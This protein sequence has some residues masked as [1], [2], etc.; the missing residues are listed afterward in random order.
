MILSAGMRTDIPAFYS[1]W[2]IN[3]VREGYVYVRNPYFRNKVTKY[4]ISPNV[5]DLLCFGTKNPHPM[6]DY[7]DELKQNYK[8]LWYITITPYGKD[9]EPNVQDKRQ[10]IE[11]VKVLSNKLGY[12]SIMI[13]YDPIC[14]NN[15][16]DVK[17]HI[18]A[19]GKLVKSLKGYVHDITI[20]FLDLYEKVKKNAPDLRAPTKEEAI[21]LAK[22][23][24]KIGKENDIVVHGCCEDRELEKYGLDMTGC[25]NQKIV[26]RACGYELN[27][28][29][30]SN[31]RGACNCIMG[32]DIGDYNSCMHLCR[33]CY[34]NYN[35]EMVFK[36]IKKH[37][38]NSPIL[39]GNIMD[40][41]IIT[42][43]KQKSWKVSNKQL[44]LNSIWSEN[45]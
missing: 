38:S 8:M 2:F 9:I 19:F 25:M 35:K 32:H 31:L 18:Y 22:A 21:E 45:N 34:A 27:P 11:D 10:V 30:S 1:K 17:K 4:I 28:P 39:I 37:D 16:F 24:S 40:D 20:S 5:I 7:I 6:L 14:M 42:E 3:R 41:D 43:A 36:N 12:E 44:S 29:K 15:Q 33:Y 13:R 26:E 23:F